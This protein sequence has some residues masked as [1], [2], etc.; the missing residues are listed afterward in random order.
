MYAPPLSPIFATC[1]A[2]LILDLNNRTTFSEVHKTLSSSLCH[3]FLLPRPSWIQIFSSPP[4]SHI[5]SAYVSPSMWATKFHTHTRQQQSCSSVYLNLYKFGYQTRRQRT[6]HQV[7]ASIPG[8]KNHVLENK[9]L[10]RTSAHN[11]AGRKLHVRNLTICCYSY[12]TS[13]P[14]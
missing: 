14:Q 12:S 13:H 4:N 2:R 10:E 8:R 3:F 1:P 5:P 7:I 11:S 9:V 6:L